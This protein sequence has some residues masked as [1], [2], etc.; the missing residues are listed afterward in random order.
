MKSFP[1]SSSRLGHEREIFREEI[2]KV[3]GPGF[4]LMKIL[5]NFI[6]IHIRCKETRLRGLR[7]LFQS[8]LPRRSKDRTLLLLLFLREHVVRRRVVVILIITH[9]TVLHG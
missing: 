3:V 8:C 2:V 6:N 4:V 9:S 7:G 5:A 1:H